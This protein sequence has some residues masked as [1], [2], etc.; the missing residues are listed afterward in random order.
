MSGRSSYSIGIAIALG[1]VAGASTVA[2]GQFNPWNNNNVNMRSLTDNWS[3][4]STLGALASNEGIYVD[5]KE[6]KINKGA[7]KGD[8]TDQIRKS[9]AR[10]VADGAII[11]RAGDKLY[12]TDGKPAQ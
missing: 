4:P 2:L 11:F 7:A 8:P 10:E 3:A 9:G 5:M 6:F 12:I 1:L